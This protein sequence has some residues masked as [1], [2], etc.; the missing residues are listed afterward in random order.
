MLLLAALAAGCSRAPDTEAIRH[1]I[2][3]MGVAAEARR[4]NDLLEHIADDFVGNAGEFDRAGLE[5][6]LRAHLLV[7]RSI[8]VSIGPVDVEVNGDR[9]T[10]RF[11]VTLTDGSGRWL[12]DRR[13]TLQMVTGWRRDEGEWLCYNARWEPK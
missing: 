7:G 9:A 11:D 1:A 10:A 3:A 12:P 13:A 8:G 5:Q 2:T 6:L 4:S